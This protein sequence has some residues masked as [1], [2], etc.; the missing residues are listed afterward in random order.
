MNVVQSLNFF[1]FLEW[2]KILLRVVLEVT[3]AG[4]SVRGSILSA[5]D[6]L[7]DEVITPK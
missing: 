5:L 1:P 2:I 3:G 6:V 4:E 7:D